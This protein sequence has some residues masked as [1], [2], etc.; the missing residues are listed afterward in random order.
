LIKYDK[1]TDK[2]ETNP[3]LAQLKQEVHWSRRDCAVHYV[4][5]NVVNCCTTCWKNSQEV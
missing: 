1:L 3:S 4:T 2:E 5:S